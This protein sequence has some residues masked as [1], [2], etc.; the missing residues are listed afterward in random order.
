M[1]CHVRQ[2]RATTFHLCKFPHALT[3]VAVD[4]GNRS[5]FPR[6]EGTNITIYTS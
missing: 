6:L 2:K 3:N 1:T 5:D 4:M